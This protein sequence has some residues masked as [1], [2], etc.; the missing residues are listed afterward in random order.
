MALEPRLPEFEQYRRVLRDEV[1]R[2]TLR[3]V[4]VRLGMSP[5]GLQNFLDGTNPYGKT[6]EK[7]RAW[8]Y[9]EYGLNH[10]SPRDAAMILRRIVGTLPAPEPTLLKIL[11]I[12]ETG[13][14]G[15]GMQA[16]RWI[17]GVRM[18]VSDLDGR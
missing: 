16:P 13:Y 5:T 9:R 8:F 3:A 12:V 2:S 6:R 10:L 4:A 14:A 17:S 1:E 11:E 7:V 15:Q 18:E